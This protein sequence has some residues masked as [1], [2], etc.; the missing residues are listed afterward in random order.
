[1]DGFSTQKERADCTVRAFANLMGGDADYQ[2]AHDALAACGRKKSCGFRLQKH[3]HD[4]A[5]SLGLSLRLIRRSGSVARLIRDF[6]TGKIL[7]RKRGHAFVINN[8]VIV[9]QQNT[10]ENAHVQHAWILAPEEKQ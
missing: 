5:R 2:K 9:D 3:V 4:V 1:M 6:P 10:S 7:V 8:G